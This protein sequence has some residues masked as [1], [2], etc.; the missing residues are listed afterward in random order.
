MLTVEMH[1]NFLLKVK[2][3][4]RTD[5]VDIQSYDVLFLLNQ[6]QNII[7]DKLIAERRMTDLRPLILSQTVL[8]AGFIATG[9]YDPGITG[10]KVVD[11]SALTTFRTFLESHSKITRSAV[12]A[13]TDV[14]MINKPIAKEDIF[15][16]ETNGTN[17]PIFT[18]PKELV[19]GK[20]L[21]VIPDAYTTTVTSI[22]SIYV[23]TPTTLVITTPASDTSDLP[24]H[25]HNEIVDIAVQLS[26]ETVNVNDIKKR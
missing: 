20:Y 15:R 23:K 1:R 9:T 17:K 5:L 3:L 2:T 12:P 26:Q 24:A 18:N 13:A 7:I 6:A 14:Y 11:L 21:I 16:W 8:A 22:T 4:D 19:D 10:A 25:L